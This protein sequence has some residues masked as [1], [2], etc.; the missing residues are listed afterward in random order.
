MGQIARG[1][2][3]EA[4]NKPWDKRLMKRLTATGGRRRQLQAKCRLQGL[5]PVPHTQTRG[6]DSGSGFYR[7]GR[8]VYY[9]C[10]VD[11]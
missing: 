6:L 11:C 2:A 4:P 9:Y 10:S 7:L 8:Y 1:R 5:L 3:A